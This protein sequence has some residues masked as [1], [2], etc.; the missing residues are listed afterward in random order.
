MN[1]ADGYMSGTSC[2]WMWF[3]TI[4][5]LLPCTIL[6]RCFWSRSLRTHIWLLCCPKRWVISVIRYSQYTQDSIDWGI[7]NVLTISEMDCFICLV[8]TIMHHLNLNNFC[9]FD[10]SSQTGVHTDSLDTWTQLRQ[11][12]TF[13]WFKEQQYHLPLHNAVSWHLTYQ[14]ILL[15]M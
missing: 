8:P 15:L 1:L 7:L 14:Y 3:K 6:A 13:P 11:V 4:T 5:C 2:I 9:C 12:W 10:M